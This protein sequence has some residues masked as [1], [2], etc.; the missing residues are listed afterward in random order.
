MQPDLQL[1]AAQS[2]LHSL[3][4]QLRARDIASLQQ[5]IGKRTSNATLPHMLLHAFLCRR[6]PVKPTASARE[7]TGLELDCARLVATK[8]QHTWRSML[9]A[10]PDRRP[11][12]AA[13]IAW[14]I[15]SKGRHRDFSSSIPGMPERRSADLTPAQTHPHE[16][17][18]RQTSYQCNIGTADHDTL[19]PG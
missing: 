3:L 17:A 1:Y 11:C 6:S 14:Q 18:R 19:L 15:C 5:Y 8:L 9:F 2:N 13:Y 4:K 12:P 10:W 16:S 7:H